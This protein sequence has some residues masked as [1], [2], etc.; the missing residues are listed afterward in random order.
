MFRASNIKCSYINYNVEKFAKK[1]LNE[2]IFHMIYESVDNRSISKAISHMSA[3]TTI[4]A[5]IKR[6]MF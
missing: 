6:F 3:E 1:N 4:Q 2:K 5:V